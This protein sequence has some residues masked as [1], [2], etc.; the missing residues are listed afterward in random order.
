MTPH[1]VTVLN[2]VQRMSFSGVS[3]SSEAFPASHQE[4]SEMESDAH[5]TRDS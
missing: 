1:H 3:G 5:R 4:I 2:T